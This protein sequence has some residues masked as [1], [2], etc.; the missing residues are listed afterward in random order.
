[1]RVKAT[2]G[3]LSAAPSTAALHSICSQGH[4]L[5]QPNVADESYLNCSNT[6]KVLKGKAR[7]RPLGAHDVV[8]HRLPS[9]SR[10]PYA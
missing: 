9:H 10:K 7:L 1:M 8:Q 5:Q 6:S 2:R 4:T 3:D